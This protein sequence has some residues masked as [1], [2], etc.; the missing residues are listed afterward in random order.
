MRVRTL[1]LHEAEGFSERGFALSIRYDPTPSTP[2]G[3]TAVLTPAWGGRAT[4]GAEA[5]WGRETAG[6]FGYGLPLGGGLVGASRVGFA[7]SEHGNDYP[8]GYGR[9]RPAA[10]GSRWA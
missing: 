1:V 9:S 2:L 6:E 10:C 3:L 4:G 8:A 5:L 7:A